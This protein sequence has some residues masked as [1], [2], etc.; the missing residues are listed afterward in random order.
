MQVVVSTIGKFHS[1]HLARQLFRHQLLAKIYTGYPWKKI[2]NEALPR[3]KVSCFP[4]IHAPYLKFFPKGLR[5]RQAWE[6]ADKTW[7]DRYCSV[8]LPE[9][10]AFI[11]LSGSAFETGRAAKSRG[12]TY[13][14][15]RGSSHICYQDRILRQ[16]FELNGASFKGFD[17]RVIEAEEREYQLADAIFVPSRFVKQTFI[18][19]G[20]PEC[21]LRLIPYG[22]NLSR[23]RKSCQ[24]SAA[25]FNVLFVGAISLR[26]G[27]QYLLPAFERLRH[28][29][30]RLIIVGGESGEPIPRLDEFRK[31]S[32]VTFA[33]HIPNTELPNLMSSSHVLVLPSVEEGLAMVQAEALACGCPVIATRHTGS[34]DLYSDAQEGFIVPIRSVE[35]LTEKLQRLAD[36]PQLR[37][38]MS[39]AAIARVAKIR[40]W[41][42]YGETVVHS[43]QSLMQRTVSSLVT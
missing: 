2:K 28:R 11:G 25:E 9:C 16:E 37:D 31:R 21:K 34:E 10:D 18:S 29:K 26:K 20:I 43:L 15:D 19:A 40:G 5:L 13:I 8:R 17:P 14:C 35:A 42:D 4:W 1:F 32:D 36:D 30:K 39:S 24:P 41:D 27:L 12:A 38:E 7:F 6:W 23:F 33:G 3:A 22:V